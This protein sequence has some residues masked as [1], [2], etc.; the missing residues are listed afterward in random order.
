MLCTDTKTTINICHL[1]LTY[2]FK[3]LV[4][5]CFM[6]TRDIYVQ[7]ISHTESIVK[8]NGLRIQQR[9]QYI[10][11]YVMLAHVIL[12]VNEIPNL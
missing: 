10:M 6:F 12:C 1:H 7:I 8:C 9:I 4:K 5:G 3:R 11:T 2:D